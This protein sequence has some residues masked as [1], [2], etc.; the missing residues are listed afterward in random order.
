[1]PLFKY[2]AYSSDG[3]LSEGEVE[4]RSSAEAEEALWRRGL[5]PFETQEVGVGG[6]G[7]AAWGFFGRRGPSSAQLASFTREFATLEQAD[8][9]LDQSLRILSTQNADPALRDLASSILR[10]IV[11]GAS[12]SESLTR[13]SG[14][15]GA[16]YVNI[17]R[18]GEA[19]G[20]VGMALD[21]MADM[22]ERRQE[23]RSRIQSSLVYPV[24]LIVLALL[25][26]V[27]VLG[28]L[29]PNIAPI[30]TDNGKPMP[31]G[32]QFIID[33]EDNW[34]IIASV[35]AALGVG[36]FAFFSYAAS[37]PHLRILIDRTLLRLPYVGAWR[38][39]HE[40]ARFARTLGSMSRAGV[41]L[42]QG[43]ESAR[44]V[45]GN[46][47]LGAQIDAV[48]ETVRG[49][50]TLSSALGRADGVPV[51]AIQMISI[52]EEVAKLDGMLLRVAEMFERQ[53]QRSVER[54]IGLLT[55]VLTI[56]IAGV[57]G[58]L[59]MTVMDAVLGINELA[60]K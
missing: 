4:A 5:T 12:L 50:A 24:L 35:F 54:V 33:V 48:I 39:Q 47:Y 55:P 7:P 29:V 16:D 40:T 58:G 30:F 10:H 36:V 17:V 23:V 20:K 25:S 26:T 28:T 21:E 27:I 49:G 18:A 57:V 19:M 60:T 37:R 34:P 9:P 32:L 59:I 38:S 8:V 15:F 6:G 22:L 52:G 3:D 56:L 51:V 11:D 2:R 1:M 14:V 31:S 43:L 53:T 41:P 42:L 44:A 46:R 45:V 13:Q